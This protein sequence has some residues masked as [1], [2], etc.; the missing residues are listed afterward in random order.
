MYGS[1]A[2]ISSVFSFCE[3]RCPTS[4]K[5]P[6]KAQT[7]KTDPAITYLGPAQSLNK[8]LVYDFRTFLEFIGSEN[9]TYAKSSPGE[10]K[11]GAKAAFRSKK[12]TRNQD[13]FNAQKAEQNH[14]QPGQM[15]A[16]RCQLLGTLS[17]AIEMVSCK[18]S[19][20]QQTAD[21]DQEPRRAKEK[22]DFEMAEEAIEICF[23]GKQGIAEV[24]LTYFI[25]EN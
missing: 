2:P 15:Q 7:T 3:K 17:T 11:T 6:C 20:Q 22:N 8:Q 13:Q 10:K 14:I 12:I 16:A 9:Q 23:R 21:P 1:E 18:D 4:S 5:N 25:G 19:S 24:K